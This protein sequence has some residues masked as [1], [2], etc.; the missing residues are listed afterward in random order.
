V[1]VTLV[2]VQN[3]LSESELLIPAVGKGFIVTTIGVLMLLTQFDA[4]LRAAA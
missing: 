3:E 1:K 2:P 4:V